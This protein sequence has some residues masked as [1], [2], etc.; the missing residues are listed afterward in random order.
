M[1]YKYCDYCK[2]D[3]PR[4]L[5]FY[6]RDKYTKDGLQSRCKSLRRVKDAIYNRSPA[7]KKTRA[8]AKNK[9]R[10]KELRKLR[11]QSEEFKIRDKDRRDMDRALL[12]D[13]YVAVNI[14][15]NKCDPMTYKEAM[16]N[17]KLLESK[18]QLMILHR[19]VYNHE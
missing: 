5:E 6:G 17:P 12:T 10:A 18:R 19:K 7:G 8:R 13:H 11:Q 14:A 2:T 16:S 15:N 3:H 9:P 4:T 1:E